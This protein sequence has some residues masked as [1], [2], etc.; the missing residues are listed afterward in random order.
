MDKAPVTDRID[1]AGLRVLQERDPH[2]RIVDVR[3]SG[4]FESMHIAGSYN[5][6]LETLVEHIDEFARVEHPVV[7]V[8]QSGGR[9][10][11]AHRR[12]EAAGK[13]T[14]YLL[15]GG[16]NAWIAAEGDV[17]RGTPR[18]ALDRQVRL[19][20][21]SVA[22]GSVVASV[23]FPRAKWLAA[24]IGCGLVYMAL[25]DTCPVSPLVAR[26][27]YNRTD[28]CDLEDVLEAFA[29]HPVGVAGTNVPHS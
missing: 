8:C 14:L 4:E 6:P 3:T 28:P 10:R 5:V 27:P 26:L 24:A 18:W 13:R 11:Q 21:G 20:A 12:L 17:R 19:M 22:I 9:A 1:V 16:L 2:V 23:L 7:L 29:Q 15:D 25:T